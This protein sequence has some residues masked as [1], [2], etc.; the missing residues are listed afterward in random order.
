MSV[1]FG[2]APKLVRDVKTAHYQHTAIKT[3]DMDLQQAIERVLQLPCVASKQF[4]IT[5]G[6]RSVGG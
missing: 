6:D 3:A 4:L 5:I 2:S 1:L